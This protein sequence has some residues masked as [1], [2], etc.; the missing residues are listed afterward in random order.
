MVEAMVEVIMVEV[1]MVAVATSRGTLIRNIRHNYVD[2]SSNQDP[3]LLA[4][5]AHLRMVNKNF[6]T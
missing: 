1:I 5:P 6:A 2:I 4:L 3:A